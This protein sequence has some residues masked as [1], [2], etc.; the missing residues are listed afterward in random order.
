METQLETVSSQ[1]VAPNQNMMEQ[2]YN[3]LGSA[4]PE[5]YNGNTFLKYKNK[6]VIYAK[7]SNDN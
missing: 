6:I 3:S 5:T 4:D 2:T 1:S 7:H